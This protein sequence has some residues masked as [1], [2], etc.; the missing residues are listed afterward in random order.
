[1]EVNSGGLL[2]PQDKGGGLN[3]NTDNIPSSQVR[4]EVLYD[5]GDKGPFIVYIESKN[6]NSNIGR[7]SHMKIAKDI[8]DLHLSDIK[9][10]KNKGLN[11]IAVEFVSF[12]AAN[13]FIKSKKLS[14]KGYEVFIPYNF[15]T[16]KALV[17]EVD[18]DLSEDILKTFF[19][20]NA[21]I[22]SIKR[23]NRKCLKDNKIEYIPTGTCLFTFKGT[24]IPREVRYCGMGMRTAIYVSPVTQCFSCL[25]YGHTK[26]NCKG[27]ERCFNCGQEKHMS[28]QEKGEDQTLYTCE[29]KCLFCKGDHRSTNKKC[30]EYQRQINIKKLMAFENLTYQDANELCKKTYEVSGEYYFNPSEFPSLKKK[31][32]NPSQEDIS[33]AQRRTEHFNG[34]KIKRSYQQA[35]LNEPAKKRIIQQKGYDKE[36]HNECLYFPNSRPDPEDLRP[37]SQFSNC[38]DDKIMEEEYSQPLTRTNQNSKEPGGATYQSCSYSYRQTENSSNID[39]FL[40]KFLNSHDRKTLIFNLIKRHFESQEDNFY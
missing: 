35:A 4:N 12:K 39:E 26:K 7:F 18:L 5:E 32:Q 38:S 20:A 17:R 11:R 31:N 2:P 37:L 10:I 3:L 27:K 23:M 8:F 1:M 29:T 16:C 14:D 22:L 36:K 25:R 6:S 30:P 21:E 9:N 19:V 34:N 15:V 33:T 24:F 13:Q 40:S 28:E